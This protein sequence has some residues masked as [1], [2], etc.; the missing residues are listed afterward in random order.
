MF[1][2]FFFFLMNNQVSILIS[3]LEATPT[4]WQNHIME[5]NVWCASS[6]LGKPLSE[7]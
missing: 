7:L 4:T 3:S 6:A 1:C 5:A 2:F